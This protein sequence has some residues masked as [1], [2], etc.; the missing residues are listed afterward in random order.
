M[1]FLRTQTWK[2]KLRLERT[3][4]VKCPTIDYLLANMKLVQTAL[5]DP[6]VLSR[7]EP[8]RE[9]ASRLAA[10]FAR[11]SVLTTDFGLSTQEDIDKFVAE[12]RQH[13]EKFVLK[14]QREGGGNNIFG[15]AVKPFCVISSTQLS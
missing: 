12:C 9:M 7:F 11:Q 15:G 6:R 5:T 1:F 2:T 3:F 4:A 10:T 8:D 14:P 13:P